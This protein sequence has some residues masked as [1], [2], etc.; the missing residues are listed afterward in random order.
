MQLNTIC[1][2]EE[3]KD[4]RWKSHER[5]IFRDLNKDNFIAYPIKGTVSTTAHKVSL[6]IQVA[7]GNVNLSSVPEY[8]RR[9]MVAETRSVLETMHRLVRAVIEC[10]ASDLDGATCRVA[11]ELERSLSARAWEGRSIQLTQVPQVGPVL[12]RKFVAAGITTIRAL[13][14]AETGDIERIASRNPPFGKKM[15]NELSSFPNLTLEVQING[16]NSLRPD[17]MPVA[18][19]DAFIGFSNTNGKPRWQGKTPTVTFLAETTKGDLAYWWRGSLRKFS[20]ADADRVSLHFEVELSDCREEVMCHFACDEIVGTV[21]S[22][23][24]HPGL[25]ASAFPSVPSKPAR[26]A[27]ADS[28]SL[29]GITSTTTSCV[30]EEIDDDDLL[31]AVKGVQ[32]ARHQDQDYSGALDD[33]DLWPVIDQADKNRR[34]EHTLQKERQ[35]KATPKQRQ[36]QSP[37][38]DA[39]DEVSWQPVRLPNGKYKCNHQ[40]A[41]AGVKRGGRACTHKCCREGVDQ[42]RRPKRPS[43]KRKADD[44]EGIGDA[45]LARNSESKR[46]A[47]RVEASGDSRTEHD[48]SHHP[49]NIP[50]TMPD[51]FL[52]DLDGFDVDDEGFIDLTQ[53]DSACEGN[54]MG[55]GAM[56]VPSGSRSKHVKSQGASTRNKPAE[57]SDIIFDGISDDDLYD[58]TI[59]SSKNEGKAFDLQ[60]EQSASTNGFSGAT[61]FEDW[62]MS[63]DDIMFLDDRTA[64][65]D[66]IAASS[67]AEPRSSPHN[68]GAKP[69]KEV[70]PAE[71]A[72]SSYP[73][74]H[75]GAAAEVSNPGA[76]DDLGI[77]SE[78]HLKSSVVVASDNTLDHPEQEGHA[79]WGTLETEEEALAS[80]SDVFAEDFVDS[81]MLDVGD[82]ED[83]TSLP[84]SPRVE[85][86]P[87]EE[88]D[89]MTVRTPRDN[90]AAV[91]EPPCG[92]KGQKG[93]KQTKLEWM[94]EADHQ[95][96]DEYL[97]LVEIVD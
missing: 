50:T 7:L 64:R 46:P 20:E 45:A 3:F 48:I 87:K 89:V 55:R 38:A 70:S 86:T 17:E 10:K 56:Q 37:H 78:D 9:P 54:S 72:P 4:F 14:Q 2:A 92:Q 39:R 83:N 31:E 73:V 42:P 58:R 69:R 65:A 16:A 25:P 91:E 80:M 62:P 6:L 22:K 35:T 27:I 36:P 63:E 94:T 33:K 76:P 49:S 40:C 90:G 34:K 32:D 88:T 61:V 97:D 60:K 59:G 96:L 44:D 85:W 84:G 93:S 13:A 47:K 8:V 43:S 79:E 11:L 26:H 74:L 66:G 75:G 41:D 23:K 67:S 53:V 68:L 52:M 81:S 28:Q 82:Q 71:L 24:L 51:N 5:D 21:V 30:E 15:L 1:E 77:V 19:I 57:D 29:G 95:I 18:R 12:M